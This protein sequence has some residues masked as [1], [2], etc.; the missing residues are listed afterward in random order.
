MSRE[1]ERRFHGKKIPLLSNSL[2]LNVDVFIFQICW[3]N[4]LTS[5]RK[6]SCLVFSSM[7][8][9][10]FQKRFSWFCVV[11]VPIR[12]QKPLASCAVLN[13]AV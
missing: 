1:E 2:Q 10:I 4:F 3:N 6:L 13:V 8:Q 9:H 12:K 7:K 5:W 11:G